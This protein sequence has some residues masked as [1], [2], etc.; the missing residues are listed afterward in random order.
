MRGEEARHPLPFLFLHPVK[1]L[2]K[3]DHFA[4]VIAG[5]RAVLDAQFIGFQFVLA[6]VAPKDQLRGHAAEIE[7]ILRGKTEHPG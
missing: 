4:R 1:R 7:N 3:S 2:K 5:A 6:T